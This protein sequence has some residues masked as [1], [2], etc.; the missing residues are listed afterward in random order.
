MEVRSDE[1]AVDYGYY[2]SIWSQAS[3]STANHVTVILQREEKEARSRGLQ[4]VSKDASAAWSKRQW[5][6]TAT[7]ASRATASSLGSRIPKS[8]FSGRL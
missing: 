7:A 5:P 4:P 1:G 6:T 3:G 8:Q 2:A